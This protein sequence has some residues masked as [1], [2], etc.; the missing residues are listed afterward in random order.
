MK[1]AS[2]ISTIILSIALLNGCTTDDEFTIKHWPQDIFAEMPDENFRSF[3]KRYDYNKDG[4]LSQNEALEVSVLNMVDLISFSACS[5][6]VG[7]EYFQNLEYISW[8]ASEPVEVDLS[9]NRKL[10]EVILW[11][12]T[13]LTLS[14]QPA[15]Q[16]I[17]CR[18]CT[19]DNIDISNCTALE[20]LEC[21]GGKLTNINYSKKCKKLS[22]INCEQNDLETI[23]IN[24]LPAFGQLDCYR[25]KKLKY[26]DVS[27][28]P[29]FG[30]LHCAG[31][32]NLETINI[33]NTNLKELVCSSCNLSEIDVTDMPELNTL[34]SAANNLTALNIINCSKLECLSC[35]ENNISQ[36]D[37]SNCPKLV[38]LDC[39]EN[40]ITQLDVSMCPELK[41]LECSDNPLT[42]LDISECLQLERLVCRNCNISTLYMSSKQKISWLDKDETTQIVYK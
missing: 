21:K 5:S 12:I 37:V 29:S 31:C 23:C 16:Q 7:I 10:K 3:C 28:N 20:W 13:S 32:K 41:T 24:N 30:F 19:F 42:T 4:K 8:H 38:S 27:N 14:K 22:W 6:I 36:L 34:L 39:S 18:D 17:F 9:K 1:K 35:S 40:A 33:R 25:C 2:L 15:L 11:N 26:L